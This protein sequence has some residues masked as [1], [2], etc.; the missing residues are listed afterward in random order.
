MVNAHVIEPSE[1]LKSII[2]K[3]VINALESENKKF[4]LAVKTVPNQITIR[5][6]EP[7]NP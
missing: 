1:P 2:S 3:A 5:Y 6:Y 4:S 7:H